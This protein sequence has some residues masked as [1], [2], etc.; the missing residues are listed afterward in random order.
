MN[1]YVSRHTPFGGVSTTVHFG[2][3]TKLRRVVDEEGFSREMRT[4]SPW[5]VFAVAYVIGLLFVL[6]LLA[7]IFR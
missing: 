3:S 7:L 6:P 2:G 1:F 4:V 5:K